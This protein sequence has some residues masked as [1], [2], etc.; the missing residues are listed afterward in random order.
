MMAII[1]VQVR[2]LRTLGVIQSLSVDNIMRV[3]PICVKVRSLGSLG[4]L[5]VN[6][7]SQMMTG[8]PS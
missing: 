8:Q 7:R 1:C 6:Q 5:R 4:S 2:S 3:T